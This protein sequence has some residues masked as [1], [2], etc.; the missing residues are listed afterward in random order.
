MHRGVAWLESRRGQ[1][2]TIDSGH[3]GRRAQAWEL[4]SARGGEIRVSGSCRMGG[5]NGTGKKKHASRGR[6][7]LLYRLIFDG[8]Y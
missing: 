3:W 4:A 6:A 5:N 7:P 8:F 1:R 2:L